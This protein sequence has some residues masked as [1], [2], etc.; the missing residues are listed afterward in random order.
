MQ[1]LQYLLGCLLS[2][3]PR[4][5]VVSAFGRALD[6]NK[7]PAPVRFYFS[8]RVALYRM[9]LACKND[10]TIALVPDYICNVVPAA[11]QAAGIPVISYPTGTLFEPDIQRIQQITSNHTSVLLC[12]A[13]VMGADGGQ[14]W[15]TSPAGRAWRA[16]N[17]IKLFMDLSQGISR[18]KDLK[19]PRLG[20]Q[21]VLLS[22][23]NNKAFPGIMGAVVISDINDRA[24]AAATCSEQLAI[25]RYLFKVALGPMIRL[26]RRPTARIMAQQNNR[27]TFEYSYCQHFPYTFAHSGATTLQIAV[28]T[29]GLWFS[30][31]YRWCKKRYVG[32]GF[33]TPKMTPFYL[34]SPYV[35]ATA[36]T[37]HLRK[38]APYAHHNNPDLSQRP[39][40]PSYHFKGFDDK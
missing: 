15:I 37:P 33:I 18:L 4:A 30:G 25:V 29:A 1:T 6:L 26:I 13:P 11:F 24:F 16:Q 10:D 7:S 39:S 36:P 3:L 5:L 2:L 31:Y 14:S 21:F 35:L 23:F 9:A 22:S 19:D 12:L 8:G 38:K 20:Q 34:S 32:K 17:N 27:A 40:I 28:A